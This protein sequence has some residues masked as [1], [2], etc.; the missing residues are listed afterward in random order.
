MGISKFLES[1]GVQFRE[2]YKTLTPTRRTGILITMVIVLTTGTLS[3]LVL[4]K[5]SYV[6]LFRNVGSDQLPTVI[7]KLK[8]KNIPFQLRD[9]GSTIAIPPEFVPATQMAIMAEAESN[10]IGSIGLELFEKQDFGTTS[11][12]QK[13]NYQRALQGELTRAINTLDVVRQSKVMLVIPN[14]KTFI[15]DS[16]PPK[17]SVVVE[18]NPGKILT[19]EQVRGISSLVASSVE[20]MDPENVSVVDSNGRLLSRNNRASGGAISQE[21]IELKDRTERTMEESIE[22]IL[23]KIVGNGKVIARVT[24]DLDTRNV[25]SVEESVDPERTAIRSVVSEE[26][27]MNG[28]RS[29]P[30]GVPGARANLP[31][32]QEAGDVSFRQDVAKELKT[33]QYDVPRTVKN[34]KEN[35]GRVERLSIAVLI[36]GVTT[37]TKGADGQVEKKW[38]PRT[39]EEVQRFEALV[40]NAIGFNEK[41]GDSI[42]VES[43]Q[44]KGEE[45]EEAS[46]YLNKLERRKLLSYLIKWMVIGLS[47]ALLFLLVVRP[48]MRW[49][50][51]SFHESVD[52]I[53][54]RT[55]EELEEL[56]SVDNSLPGMGGSMPSIQDSMDP[57]KA[58]GELLK[59]RILALI[60]KDNVKAA[61]ALSLWLVRKD[62]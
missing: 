44:F 38:A 58:E 5:R 7:G 43:I 51:E 46:T 12:V 27:K 54:P 35:P 55:I 16:T 30:S 20:G 53:L 14:K 21:F 57:D 37:E 1:L 2:F 3:V 9:D 25:S 6:T 23:A 61:D 19:P 60:E 56:Q 41:R 18:L 32:A 33:T 4:T 11:Y 52:D 8:E 22:E 40:K 62:V 31:G 15:E 34:I 29:N 13:I 49:I 47:L 36:D 59:D 26:E 39:P 10:K 50:T 48:F 24:A 45:F 28:N 17:A 42:K